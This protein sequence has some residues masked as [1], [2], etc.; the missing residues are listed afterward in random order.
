MSEKI[1]PE[2]LRDQMLATFRGIAR[3]WASLPET[4]PATGN[5]LTTLDRCE[6]VVFSVL[7]QLDGCGSLP[8]FD[9]IAHQ[10]PDDDDQQYEGVVISEMLHEHF[11]KRDGE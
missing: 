10:H 4:D 5:T 11:Y 6:G 2:A 8:S 1:A 9:L 7:A 3:Y